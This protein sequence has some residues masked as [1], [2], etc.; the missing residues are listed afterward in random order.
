MSRTRVGKGREDG[1]GPRREADWVVAYIGMERVLQA[2][3]IFCAVDML[4]AC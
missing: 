3:I 2:R 1:R 4:G